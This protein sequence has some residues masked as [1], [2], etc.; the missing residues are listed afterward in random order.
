MS[1][2]PEHPKDNEEKTHPREVYIAPFTGYENHHYVVAKRQPESDSKYC[3][4]IKHSEHLKALEDSISKQMATKLI[5][6]A[7]LESFSNVI[8]LLDSNIE[9]YAEPAKQLIHGECISVINTLISET[10]NGN[11]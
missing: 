6:Q 8:K 3:K 1:E 11:G 5:R 4:Y 9:C 2:L 7:K 10:E